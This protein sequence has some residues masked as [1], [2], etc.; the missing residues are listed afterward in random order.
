[1]NKE[2]M[3]LV[4]D[5]KDDLNPEKVINIFI[6]DMKSNGQRFPEPSDPM[7]DKEFTRLLTNA[8]DIGVPQIYPPEALGPGNE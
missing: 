6:D 3:T 1:M 4:M 2:E 7:N 8:Y 5:H